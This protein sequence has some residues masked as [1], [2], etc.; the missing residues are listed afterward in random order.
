M[1]VVCTLHG[2]A[3]NATRYVLMGSV[4]AKR[5]VLVA[6]ESTPRTLPLATAVQPRGV[7]SESVTRAFRSG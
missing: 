7:V 5:K 4:S 6:E 1:A 3:A 2:P